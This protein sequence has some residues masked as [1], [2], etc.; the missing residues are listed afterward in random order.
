[1]SRWGRAWQVRTVTAWVRELAGPF[2]KMLSVLVQITPQAWRILGAPS[3]EKMPRL[4]T[5]RSS[6]G[7]R[8]VLEMVSDVQI[9]NKAYTLAKQ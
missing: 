6:Q 3:S 8:W 4:G 1:M 2:W 7:N 9:K 5:V